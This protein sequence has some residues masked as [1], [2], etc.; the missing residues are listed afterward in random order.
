MSIRRANM[1][2]VILWMMV[3][4]DGFIEGPDRELDWHRVDEDLHTYINDSLRGAAAFLYGR[5]CFEL[6]AEFWPTADQDPAIPQVGEFARIWRDTPKVV[7]STTLDHADWNSRVVRGDIAAEIEALRA[8]SGDGDLIL[9]GGAGITESMGRLGL[10]DEYHLFL[11]PVVLGSGTR[12][13]PE[14]PKRTDLEL[15]G[16]RQFNDGVL[17]VHYGRP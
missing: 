3:S 17:L 10:I 6:M 14:L 13:L 1:R 12:L 2:K 8:Q 7:F 15:I 16:T 11:H 9:L 5:T 4:L